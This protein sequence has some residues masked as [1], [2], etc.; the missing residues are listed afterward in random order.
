[1]CVYLVLCEFRHAHLPARSS[2][3]DGTGVHDSIVNQLLSKI[4]GVNSLNNILLIGM[5]NRKDM[6]D[7]EM[8]FYHSRL[9]FVLGRGIPFCRVLECSCVG[10]YPNRVL[11][12]R[13]VAPP[14]PFGSPRG[15]RFARSVR[16]PANLE[17]PHEEVQSA[18]EALGGCTC[19]CPFALC[20]CVESSVRPDR[21]WTWLLWPHARKTSPA[22]NWRVS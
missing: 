7:G 18:Q 5:T 22:L 12:R 1:M 19:P 10:F 3:R 20:A 4:Q 2:S 9:N 17:H 11:T 15:N 21:M 6:I 13:G 16:P 8:L 14:R